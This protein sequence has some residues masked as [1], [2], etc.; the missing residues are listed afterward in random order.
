MGTVFVPQVR[1]FLLFQVKETG[2]LTVE[3]SRGFAL[4]LDYPLCARAFLLGAGLPAVGDKG[5]IKR[6]VY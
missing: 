1:I 2:I 4:P 6:T 5:V 3:Q